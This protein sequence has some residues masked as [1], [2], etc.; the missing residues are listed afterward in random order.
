MGNE[1]EGDQMTHLTGSDTSESGNE[2]LG[3]ISWWG[4]GSGGVWNQ[5]LKHRHCFLEAGG[6]SHTLPLPATRH[7][8]V[9]VFVGHLGTQL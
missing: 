1:V 2:V 9:G 7:M 5:L 6:P 4:A 3:K 8:A